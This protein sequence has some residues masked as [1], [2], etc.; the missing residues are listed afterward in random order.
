ME[1]RLSDIDFAALIARPFFPSPT[2]WEDEVLYFLMLD[3]FSDGNETNVLDNQGQLVTGPGTPL[4][5]GGD[6]NNAIGTEQD[7]AAWRSA[8]GN[9]VGGTINGLHSKLGYLRRLGITAIWISPVFKQ[10]KFRQD[11]YHGYGIQNF[12]DVDPRFGTRDELKA[13]V[14]TAHSLGIRVV[15]DVILNHSGDVFDYTPES[16]RCDVFDQGQLVGKEHC[17]QADG[18][19]YPVL[20]F[21]DAQGNPTLSFGPVGAGQ[22]PD[23]AIWPEE[24]QTPEA[25]TRKGSIRNWDA[26]PEPQEG[27]FMS[28]KDIALGTGPV[29]HYAPSEALL[30]LCQVFKFW[31]AFLDLDGFR[32]D[33]VKHMDD[34]ASRLFTA[35]IREFAESI[36]KENFY[37]IG[38]ITGGRTNAIETLERVGMSAALG[39]E[40]IPDKLEYLVKGFRDP[41]EYFELFRNSTLIG[42]ESHTWLRDK[43]VTTLDDHDQVRKGNGKSRFA[44]DEGPAQVDSQRGSLAVLALLTLSLGIPCI[45]YGTEQQFDGN[46]G[47]DRFIRE[48]MFGGNFGAFRSKGRHFFNEGGL[49]FS[50]LSKL[51]RIRKREI[52]LRRG[53]QYLRQISGNGVDFG[54]PTGFAGERLRSIV[55]WSRLFNDREVLVAINT[56]FDAPSTAWVTVDDSLHRAGSVLTCVYSS[57]AAQIGEQASVQPRNG[58]SVLLTVPAAGVVIWL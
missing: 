53:R 20:G 14:Q 52:V 41:N 17:W 32:V 47:N 57:D 38:E 30:D 35:V 25:F 13:L 22:F 23:G 58:K 45:Y 48:A 1:L 44:H 31:I 7:A 43:V 15:L 16:A 24:F 39:I 4:Y 28:L 18:S 46:G 10:V 42:K 3:R 5:F 12:L 37:L 40:D 33:T 27:D 55:P 8:G 56:D 21:R 11:T 51:L 6:A 34:G 26:R 54:F 9:F 2:H 49:V 50:E 19:R 36:G 29:D